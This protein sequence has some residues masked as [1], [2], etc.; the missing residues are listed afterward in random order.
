MRNAC[1]SVVYSGSEAE[2]L[3]ASLSGYRF[4]VA[5]KYARDINQIR[6]KLIAILIDVIAKRRCARR[7]RRKENSFKNYEKDHPARSGLLRARPRRRLDRSYGIRMRAGDEVDEL[8][9]GPRLL[10]ARVP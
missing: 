1:V 3:R 6:S 7:K 2:F 4:F 8:Q 5:Q 10:V 9:D